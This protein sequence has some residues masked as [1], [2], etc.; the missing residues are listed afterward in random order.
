VLYY[1]LGRNSINSSNFKL[2]LVAT[3]DPYES[4]DKLQIVANTM[5]IQQS[6]GRLTFS[7]KEFNIFISSLEHILKNYSLKL[8]TDVM[9]SIYVVCY[10]LISLVLPMLFMLT[11]AGKIW[12][13]NQML[14][15]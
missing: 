12:P 13:Q 6:E 10:S 14:E 2:I 3:T 15:S 1:I 9:G 7:A 4:S 8:P 5:D 11:S